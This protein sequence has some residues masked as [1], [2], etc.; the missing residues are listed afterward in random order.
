MFKQGRGGG[1]VHLLFMKIFRND[2]SAV[3][4]FT[5]TNDA[6]STN[7]Q[8]LSTNAGILVWH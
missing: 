5:V 2:V 1:E 7:K 3:Q 4:K 8:N 6:R